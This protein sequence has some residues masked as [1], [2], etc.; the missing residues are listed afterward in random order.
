M[1]F[2]KIFDSLKF[3]FNWKKESSPTQKARSKT[4]HGHAAATVGNHSPIQQADVIHNHYPDIEKNSEERL[5]DRVLQEMEYNI[6]SDVGC[7]KCHFEFDHHNKLLDSNIRKE[8]HEPIRELIKHM[9]LCNAYAGN[10]QLEHTPSSVKS[11][12]EILKAYLMNKVILP[13]NEDN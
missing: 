1:Q 12:S 6:S 4:Q 3:L 7:P 13:K 2:P 8:L 5:I 11:Q 10:K 9:K